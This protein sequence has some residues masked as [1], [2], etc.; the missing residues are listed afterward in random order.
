MQGIASL[1]GYQQGGVTSPDPKEERRQRLFQLMAERRDARAHAMSLRPDT[2]MGADRARLLSYLNT[3]GDTT[4]FTQEGIQDWFDSGELEEGAELV[5]Q[6]REGTGGREGFNRDMTIPLRNTETYP[7]RYNSGGIGHY[8]S[9]DE[10]PSVSSYGSGASNVLGLYGGPSP[11]TEGVD[12]ISLNIGAAF[13]PA[14]ARGNDNPVEDRPLNLF[15]MAMARAGMNPR[16]PRPA[17]TEKQWEQSPEDALRRVYGHELGH[18]AYAQRPASNSYPGGGAS[19][20]KQ[21]TYADRFASALE[22]LRNA[23]DSDS[24]RDVLRG[25]DRIK[26][27]YPSGYTMQ[28][29]RRRPD[30]VSGSGKFSDP[31]VIDREVPSE[32]LNYLSRR[33]GDH[34]DRILSTKQFADHP[35]NRGFVEKFSDKVRRGIGSLRR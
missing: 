22:A 1:R 28:D 8:G 7:E 35:L 21:E 5:R 2:L 17:R 16:P 31:T 32:P 6:L 13:G 29:F 25:A 26:H 15:E 27:D 10:G 11:F 34:M 20:R 24:W 3:E 14:Y 33:Y 19:I 30:M 9:T 18:A 23:T 12:E 4:G